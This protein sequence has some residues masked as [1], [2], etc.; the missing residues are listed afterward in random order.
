MQSSSGG[1]KSAP[2]ALDEETLVKIA[3]DISKAEEEKRQRDL[4]AKTLE[5][6]RPPESVFVGER[7]ICCLEIKLCVA[8]KSKSLVS[9]VTIAGSN[10]QM[11]DC[12]VM[13]MKIR[14]GG[15]G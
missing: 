14:R 15:G 6:I 11:W 4:N 2:S 12:W 3:L 9:R 5:E 1:L 13:G 10:T 7:T 8:S